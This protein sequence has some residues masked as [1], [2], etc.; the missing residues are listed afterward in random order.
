[1]LDWLSDNRATIA[2]F[3]ILTLVV[4]FIL[5]IIAGRK[6]TK[7]RAKDEVFGDPERTKGGWHWAICGRLAMLILWSHYSW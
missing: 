3:I 4:S 2:L 7:L 5:S 6:Q 1:M